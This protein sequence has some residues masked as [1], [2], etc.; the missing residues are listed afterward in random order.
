[1][2]AEAAQRAHYDRIVAAYDVHYDDEWSRRYRDEFINR[3]LLDGLDLRGRAVL[4][5]MCGSGMTTPA[6]L[7]RGAQVT[8]LDISQACIDSFRTRWPDCRN[9]CASIAQSGLPSEAFDAVVVVGGL[10]HLQPNVA[11]AIDEIYRVLK[12]GGSFSFFEPHT[13]SLPDLFRQQ[14][15]KRDALFQDN[16]AAIDLERLKDAYAGK[17]DF[18][19]ETYGGNVGFLFVFNSFIFRIPLRLKRYYSPTVLR[20]EALL[21]RLQGR[22]LACTVVCQ[23]RKK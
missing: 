8:G 3:P 20:L 14:W 11:P 16:E 6:L 23:W 1:M 10:H 22:R 12:P 7:S 13:G 4:E 2:D 5:A 19:R 17:F 9:A 18:V 15:Y 21:Q